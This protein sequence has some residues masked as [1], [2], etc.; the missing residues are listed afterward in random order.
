LLLQLSNPRLEKANK[1]APEFLRG[2]SVSGR[3]ASTNCFDDPAF[4]ISIDDDGIDTA[5]DDFHDDLL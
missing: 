4:M 3:L 2:F 5:L 1:E